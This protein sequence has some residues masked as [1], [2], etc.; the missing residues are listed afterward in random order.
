MSKMTVNDNHLRNIGCCTFKLFVCCPFTFH[1]QKWAVL[2]QTFIHV[3]PQYLFFSIS[4]SSIVSPVFNCFRSNPKSKNKG[5]DCNYDCQ[6]Y[7]NIPAIGKSTICESHDLYVSRLERILHL[8]KTSSLI[9]FLF[10][11]QVDG[12]KRNF[13]LSGANTRA[14]HCNHFSNHGAFS[15]YP[16]SFGIKLGINYLLM[17][18]SQKFRLLR[19]PSAVTLISDVILIVKSRC[20]TS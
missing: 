6:R 5:K 20:S 15:F 18:S 9:S 14:G 10:E 2:D 1:A 8:P 4:D 12:L 3:S 7:E 19:I 13:E 11:I 17:G 16:L